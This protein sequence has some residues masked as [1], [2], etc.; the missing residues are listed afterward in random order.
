M[1]AKQKLVRMLA[2]AFIM[3]ITSIV[4]ITTS[5]AAFSLQMAITGGT[6]T[7]KVGDE[8]EVTLTLTEATTACN[9]DINYNQEVYDFVKSGTTGLSAAVNGT[10]VSCMYVDMNLTGTTTLKVKFK[11][12]AATSEA[13]TFSL[14]DAKFCT[15]ANEEGYTANN[16]ITISKV[17]TASTGTNTSNTANTSGGSSTTN[18]AN[19]SGGSNTTNTSNTAGGSNK[20]NIAN[21]ANGTS[22]GTSVAGNQTSGTTTKTTTTTTASTASASN[23]TAATSTA[24]TKLPNAGT[25]ENIGY[26]L[27]VC[28]I[29][30]IISAILKYKENELSKILKQA[31]L[32]LV[33]GI[34]TLTS[35]GTIKTYAATDGV[36]VKF[37]NTLISNN[38]NV[39][40]A[41]NKNQRQLTTKEIKEK[42]STISKITN[43]SGTEKGETENIKTGDKIKVGS[44]EYEAI[45]YGDANGDGTICDSS[46]VILIVKDYLG[47]LKLEGI[48]FIAANLANG[49]SKLD[50]SDAMKMVK[51][52]QNTSTAIVTTTPTGEI[53]P[54]EETTQELKVGD[55]VN[56]TPQTQTTTY[57]VEAKYSGTDNDQK[58][59]QDSLKWRVLNVNEDGTVD[60]IG[61]PTSNDLYLCGALG[62]NNGVYLLNDYCKTLYSNESLNATARSL[63]IEDIQD[64]MIWDY[65]DYTDNDGVKY[66]ETRT[67]ETN[68]YYPYQWAQEK[69]TKNKIDG[70]STNGTLGQS[71]QQSLTENTYSEAN[72]S[73]EVEQT[74]WYRSNDN[75]K[76]TF[77]EADTREEEN[78]TSMYYKLLCNN[79]NSYYW[80]AS[81]YYSTYYASGAYFGL[82]HVFSGGIGSYYLFISDG[83]ASSNDN[84]VRPVVS[85]PSGVI[86]LETDYNTEGT[87]N[88][89]IN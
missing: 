59:S 28:S 47:E 85:L 71:E 78:K 2:I 67:Y 81:R 53:E 18:T 11:A 48:R 22:G 1:K 14:S 16:S 40:I 44:T 36:E 50:S 73:I 7:V 30:M 57:T 29:I 19:T 32:M 83:Y 70:S 5:N 75:M 35:V 62:Y 13:T 82:G 31:G 69:S 86:D 27:L 33:L 38:N 42:K 6:S 9:F 54:Q 4:L 23:T 79:G 10:K 51:V 37:Y 84:R 34:V 25:R 72:T 39:T 66:G 89:R 52:Y 88:L 58:F 15:E 65:H 64:K 3:L 60:L 45:V 61:E 80:L 63:N 49:N 55:Y 56:Y 43:S 17:T 74:Y 21:V 20:T 68:K 26:V 24:S 8:V 77:K 76:T 41:S 12:K 87:W 46:D